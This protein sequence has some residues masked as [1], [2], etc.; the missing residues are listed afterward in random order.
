MAD[1]ALS[2]LSALSFASHAFFLEMATL[3]VWV[4]TG[5]VQSIITSNTPGIYT[6]LPYTAYH[7]IHSQPSRQ[8]RQQD[9]K[10]ARY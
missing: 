10:E 6:A 1:E 9:N 5:T 2:S 4:K 3:S 7:N 8:Q